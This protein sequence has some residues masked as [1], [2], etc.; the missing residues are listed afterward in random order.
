MIERIHT[1]NQLINSQT[2][3]QQGKQ[4]SFKGAG[5]LA[6]TGLRALNNSPAIG[7]CAVDLCSM[8]IPRTI[9]ETKN[10]G[11]ESG[12]ETFFREVS[13][14]LIHA[15][16]GLIG[17]GASTVISSNINKEYGM[18][19]QK[20][21]VSGDTIKNMSERWVQSGNKSQ[22]FF[23]N[24]VDGIKGLNGTQW[25]GISDKA[26][27]QV[28]KKLTELAEKT[29][30]LSLKT[31]ADKKKALKEVKNLKQVLVN[32]IIKDTGAQSSFVLPEIVTETVGNN[33]ESVKNV[34]KSISAN[35][36]ELIDNA[37]GLNNSFKQNNGKIDNFVKSLSKN[38]KY[39]TIVGLG[40][41][42]IL[43]MSVQP[44]NK[45][46]T[47][48]RTGKDGFVGVDNNGGAAKD[49]KKSN[50]YKPLKTVTGIA[51]PIAALRTIGKFPELISNIQ[52]NS[53]VPSIN[54]FKCLYGL[55]I[56][57]RLMS[58]RD[59]NELRESMIKDT[60]GFT[61][62][63]ILGGMVSKLTARVIGGK[64]LINN[65]VVAEEGKKGLKYAANWLV[66]SSVKTFDEV[67][68]P[69][70]KK[71]QTDGK[72]KGYIDLYKK[73]SPQI[74][75]KISKV[76]ISQVAG[77]LYSGIVLGV[78]ISKLNI[79]ITKKL[80]ARKA[81]SNNAQAAEAT[82]PNKEVV[83]KKKDYTNGNLL[84]KYGA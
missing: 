61:N 45:Y 68:L 39:S 35:I 49:E 64:D 27:P 8:V 38:K 12:I 25:N 69:S 32:G 47:K 55:T 24:F 59:G 71:I 33:G 80:N 51:F 17:L 20:L 4:N 21:F 63:L 16:V 65:P 28:V 23:E 76:A 43:C 1:K 18:K 54:Q 15:C 60:L 52:F 6:L 83:N 58:S 5:T 10:R 67:L 56:G 2:N 40:I 22:E 34:T 41:C 84:K 3:N 77:Y 70:A 37:V 57:S 29:Q 53:K 7:A 62:W 73:A 19:A 31:G 78:G 14:C 50:L 66:K 72:V 42:A 30:A 46:L 36:S 82:T 26:K 48:K 44:L 74:K 79:F 81:E 11:K 9:V 13:S 75:S